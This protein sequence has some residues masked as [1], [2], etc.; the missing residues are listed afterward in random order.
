MF[1]V[2]DIVKDLKYIGLKRGD[3][4]NIK[5]SMRSIGEMED[6]ANTLIQA[7]IEVVGDDGLIVTDSFISVYDKGSDEYNNNVSKADSSSYA[8][9]LANVM[10]KRNDSFRSHHPIQK[11]CMI[12]KRAE[13]MALEHTKESYAYNILKI[14]AENGAVNLKIGSDKK[15]PGVGTTHV[16]IGIAGIEQYRKELMVQYLNSN[17]IMDHFK[18]NWAGACT[19]AIYQL[20]EEYE[21][22]DGA[23]LAHGRIGNA[24][25]KL[26]NMAQ[27]LKC[28]L[29]LINKNPVKFLKCGD[30]KCI[31]CQLTWLV[32]RKNPLLYA[33]VRLFKGDIRSCIRAIRVLSYNIE[34]SLVDYKS[35][36]LES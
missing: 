10:I 19:K 11:F 8:G 23:V 2:N 4:V 7:L 22:F 13:K 29:A 28:E 32:S 14:M 1:S 16:A 18:I 31:T 21:K 30:D 33:I 15:V 5:A 35:S 12:G 25:A 9:V 24:S 17:G 36:D 6:G 20:N 26:T 27:T 34:K 3:L